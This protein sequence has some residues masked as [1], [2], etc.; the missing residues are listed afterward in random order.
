MPSL[1]HAK[2][3]K[4]LWYDRAAHHLL[5]DHLVSLRLLNDWPGLGDLHGPLVARPLLAEHL[6]HL[7][8]HFLHGC[9]SRAFN[10]R[11]DARALLWHLY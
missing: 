7:Q 11:R 2:Y 3:H 5:A 1:V 8:E 6:V 4:R 9:S 10:L